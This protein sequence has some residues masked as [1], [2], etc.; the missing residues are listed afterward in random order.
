MPP[1]PQMDCFLPPW[2]VGR[3]SEAVDRMPFSIPEE[4]TGILTRDRQKRK[5]PRP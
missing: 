4:R 2:T 1:L 5:P 3:P